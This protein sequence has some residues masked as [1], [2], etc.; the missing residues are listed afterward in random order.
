MIGKEGDYSL[1]Q[2]HV[3]H[4][5]VQNCVTCQKHSPS[6]NSLEILHQITI[7]SSN[8]GQNDLPK[9]LRVRFESENPI[10]G[11]SGDYLLQQRLINRYPYWKHTEFFYKRGIS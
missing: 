9:S 7:T 2:E 1:L 6:T 4:E 10:L 5:K 3:N 11:I 8:T